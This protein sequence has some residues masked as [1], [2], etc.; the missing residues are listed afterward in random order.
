MVAILEVV[1]MIQNFIYY[2]SI[3][4]IYIRLLLARLDAL[5]EFNA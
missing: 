5:Q 2:L 3:S 1:D 4:R